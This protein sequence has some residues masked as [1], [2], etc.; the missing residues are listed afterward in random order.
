MEPEN[1]DALL[2]RANRLLEKGRPADSLRCLD[3]LRPDALDADDRI[4]LVSLR[5]WAL[6]D[7]GRNEEA[8]D[9]L[10]T[11]L[12]EFPKS[13]RLLGALGMVLSNND[14]L[15]DARDALEEAIAISPTD[16][17]SRANLAL[18][19]EKLRDFGRALEL[20]EQALNLG[21]DVD[22]ILQR[23]AAALSECGRFADA[24]QT[25]KRY[26]SLVPDDATQW[27]TL[28][29]LC[30]DDE[31]Y[32]E[33]FRCYEQAERLD[34]QAPALRLNWGVSAVRARRLPVDCLL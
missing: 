22:W 18:V 24:K 2:E 29:I 25:L 9:A 17:V 19:Y 26:L 6:S 1:I 13:P 3:E 28:G 27:I 20:Y 15:E 12:D 5:A 33:A 8:L 7:L 23:E 16:E 4:E 30:S 31:E 34:P 21:A 10:D 14:E 32:D 11:L